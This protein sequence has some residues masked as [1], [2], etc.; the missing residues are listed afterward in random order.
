M[1]LPFK[2]Y[3]STFVAVIG[4]SFQFGY[5]LGCVNTPSKIIQEWV[6]SSFHSLHGTE[7]SEAYADFI[8]ST[9]VSIFSIGGMI[10]ALSSGW[11]ANKWGRKGALIKNNII[12]ILAII[13]M[14][15]SK[16]VNVFYLLIIGRFIIGIGCGFATGLVP[17]YITEIAPDYLR[18]RFGS[19]H[20]LLIVSGIVISNI[21]GFRLVAGNVDAWPI[22]FA[23]SALPAFIQIIGLFFIPESPKYLLVI[24]KDEEQAKESL[25]QLRPFTDMLYEI[26][27]LKAEATVEKGS[28]STTLSDMFRYPLLWP[29]VISIMMMFSQQFSGINA[30]MFYSAKIF[31]GAGLTGDI[32]FYGTLCISFSH[33]LVTCLSIVLIDHPRFGRRILHITGLSGM[34]VLT[35]VIALS[36]F[37]AESNGVLKVYGQ[38]VSILGILLFALFFSIGPGSIPWFFVTEL[39]DSNSRSQG[40][41]IACL[42]NWLASFIVG[43][44]FLPLTNIIGPYVFF[45][46]TGCLL[47]SIIFTYKFVP[48]TKNKTISE[49][50][51]KLE[52]IGQI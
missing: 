12:M 16:F 22:V 36:L 14:T 10:G 41:S 1:T 42:C 5:N 7:L 3:F 40:N 26:E 44:T 45:I 47:F 24:K 37:A 27:I 39:F 49:I 20:Q 46:F 21:I 31:Q 18:G 30:A 35:V 34:M 52:H 11:A 4:G 28:D 2:L 23:F 15:L 25:I 38:Y 19:V 48:E 17:L 51:L 13:L 8:W 32:P 9:I 6:K 29:L 33:L 50:K 43:L